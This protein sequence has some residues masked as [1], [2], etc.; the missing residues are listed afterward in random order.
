MTVPEIS[1]PVTTVSTLPTAT[2]TKVYSYVRQS[3]VTSTSFQAT[4]E[5]GR[6]DHNGRV[7]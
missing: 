1:A 6:G 5:N 4:Q 7:S 3:P 2:S